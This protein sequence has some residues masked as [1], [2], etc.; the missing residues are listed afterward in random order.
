M[1]NYTERK[2][3]PVLTKAFRPG[4]EIAFKKTV[5]A[6][7]LKQGYDCLWIESP[8]T[9]SGAPDVLLFI[10]TNNQAFLFEFKVTDAAGYATFESTQALY[11]K[12]HP[13]MPIK[14]IAYDV[15]ARAIIVRER[16]EVLA[17][18]TRHTTLRVPLSSI[19]TKSEL[20]QAA[21]REKN[22]VRVRDAN[23]TARERE[24]YKTAY[25]TRKREERKAYPERQSARNKVRTAL[26]NGTL[27]RS[28]TCQR[29]GKTCRTD[30]H[31]AD[32]FKPLLVAWLCRKC[33]L[34][35]HNGAK[36]ETILQ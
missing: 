22:P 30:A 12:Q 8:E 13:K 33:Y 24:D 7:W 14:I 21:W 26:A 36:I 25:A 32:Y 18:M 9:A 6:W 19:Q 31:H 29:C 5:T 4:Q 15:S 28:A 3:F 35:V 34:L 16:A 20:A 1:S 11:Y 10:G 17:Y 27:T 23:K 2:Y